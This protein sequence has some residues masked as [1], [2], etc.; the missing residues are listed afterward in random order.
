MEGTGVW[1]TNRQC[2]DFQVIIKM[3]HFCIVLFTIILHIIIFCLI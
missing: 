3:Q 2:T 1:F